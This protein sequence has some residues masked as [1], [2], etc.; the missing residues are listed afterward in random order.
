M[1]CT[2]DS[3]VPGEHIICYQLTISDNSLQ[4]VVEECCEDESNVVGLIIVNF[5]KSYYL[6]N[7]VLKNGVPQ[8]PPIY[9]VSVGD[10]E[11]IFD[12]IN[13]QVDVGDAQVRVL[14]ESVVDSVNLGMARHSSSSRLY[15][16][17]Y[18]WILFYASSESQSMGL[19]CFK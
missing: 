4:E 18:E 13:A 19:W 12:F 3:G 6:P 5:E 9:V 1:C 8:A 16:G 2:S 14:V 11:Q 10:G 15:R 7:N 17:M